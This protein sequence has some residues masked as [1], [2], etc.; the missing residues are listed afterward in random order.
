MNRFLVALAMTLLLVGCGSQKGELCECEI[1]GRVSNFNDEGSVYLIDRWDAGAII[2]STA[3]VDNT[4]HFKSVKHRPTFAQLI[5]NNGRPIADLFVE[6]GKIYVVGDYL[7][8]AIKP[9]GTPSNEAF[10]ALVERNYDML[11]RLRMAIGKQDKVAEKSVEDE[12]A[13]TLNEALEKNKENVFGLYLLHL[14]SHSMP[15]KEVLDRL[16]SLP[17]ALQKVAFAERLKMSSERRFKTEPQVEGSDYVPHYIDIEQPNLEGE[18]VSLKSVVESPQNRYVL[19]NFWASWWDPSIE[20]AGVLKQVYKRYHNK[21]F[22]IYGVSLDRRKESLR[23]GIEE[24]GVE[25]T[26]VCSYEEYASSAVEAYAIDPKELP[27]FLI[28][29]SN[30]VIIAKNLRGEE[31]LSKL[32]E[33][34]K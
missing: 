29:C 19:L 13:S 5:M 4:F 12:I 16:S 10:M 1:V 9:S 25:W 6:D 26:T 11:G 7:G 28:D 14:Q 8:G 18:V 27:N 31:L 2:D 20:E 24:L 3:M 34:L 23:E 21:G 15:S 32:S 30:G 17:V 33:L 22:E